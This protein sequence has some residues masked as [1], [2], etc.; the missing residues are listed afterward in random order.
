MLLPEPKRPRRVDPLPRLELAL[1][2]CEEKRRY[3]E[4]SRQ[5]QQEV[6]EKAGKQQREYI[7]REQLRAIQRELGELD[8]QES[9]V[10]ELRSQLEAKEPPEEVKTEASRE[11]ARLESINPASPEYSVIRTRLDWILNLPWSDPPPEPYR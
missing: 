5:I 7:L 4:V 6:G 1:R 8:P 11:L 9:E 10:A 2:L 3:L